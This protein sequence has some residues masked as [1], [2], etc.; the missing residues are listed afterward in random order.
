M[1]NLPQR[2][3]MRLQGYD[4][5][6]N[7]AY[8]ITICT[9]NRLQIFGETVGATL[10]GRPNPVHAMLGKWLV[11]TEHKYNA[12][13]I[14]KYVIMPNHIHCIIILAGD[15]TGSPLPQILDWFKTM[16]TNEYIRGV[17]AGLYPPFYQKIWQR[18]YHDHIIRNEQEY[19]KIWEYIDT[20]PMKWE[21][22]CFHCE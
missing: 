21:E 4:Y 3:R 16:T 17:K 2:K 19:Q 7:G 10:C 6:Q 1:G 15:H 14:D 9:E 11:E 8:F 12:V 20:N 13:T 5:A 22:D 18:S